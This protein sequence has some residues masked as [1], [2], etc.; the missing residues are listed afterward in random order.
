M[1]G[2]MRSILGLTPARAAYLDEAIV[3]ARQEMA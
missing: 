3:Q 1:V 2:E